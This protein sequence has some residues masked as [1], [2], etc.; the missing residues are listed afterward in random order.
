MVVTDY[1]IL[2][3]D[4]CEDGYYYL[5]DIV[6]KRRDT[7][8]KNSRP[9]PIFLQLCFILVTDFEILVRSAK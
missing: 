5:N 7:I 9:I 2:V 6:W 3:I 8:L 4:P 1:E